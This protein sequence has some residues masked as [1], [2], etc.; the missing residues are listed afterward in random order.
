VINADLSSFGSTREPLTVDRRW[1]FELV[2]ISASKYRF[3]W[4]LW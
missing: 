3:T 1:S 4:F 2:W